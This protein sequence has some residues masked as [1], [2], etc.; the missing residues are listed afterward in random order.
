MAAGDFIRQVSSRT[1]VK[2]EDVGAGAAAVLDT[3]IRG[4]QRCSG[5]AGAAERF[6]QPAPS[7]QRPAGLA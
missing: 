6:R 2:A 5:R 3:P 1:G 7:W 4:S